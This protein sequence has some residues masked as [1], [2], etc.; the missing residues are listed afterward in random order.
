MFHCLAN[1]CADLFVGADP[2]ARQTPQWC[3][4]YRGL[5]HSTANAGC[6]KISAH[7]QDYPQHVVDFATLFI[8]LQEQRH[9]ADYN[10]HCSFTHAA[11]KNL[12]GEVDFAIKSFL[13][14]ARNERMSLLS[15]TM[16]KSRRG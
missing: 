6:K 16:F 4:V 14:A 8:A 5:E 9:D 3:H 7:P 2:A 13:T 1:E 12:I 15:C 10:P 11:V